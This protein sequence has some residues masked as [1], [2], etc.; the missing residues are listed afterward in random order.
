MAAVN[1]TFDFYRRIAPAAYAEKLNC[2][3]WNSGT[4]FPEGNDGVGE[5]LRRTAVTARKT[6]GT[7]SRAPA[8]ATVGTTVGEDGEPRSHATTAQLPA[9]T[10]NP[11]TSKVAM[12]DA[13]GAC[14]RNV[15]GSRQLT[16]SA[17][18]ARSING[19]FRAMQKA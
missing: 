11:A 16:M 19:H 9:P 5:R 2:G 15:L 1:R 10:G 8:R 6:N 18:S 4:G 14:T 17:L 13:S 3:G 12:R 7:V